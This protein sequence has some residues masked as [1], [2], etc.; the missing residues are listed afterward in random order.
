MIRDW[1]LR[2]YSYCSLKAE[3][4]WP[5]YIELLLSM[6][7]SKTE[8]Y[9]KADYLQTF[10]A[11]IPWPLGLAVFDCIVS[12]EARVASKVLQRACLCGIVDGV[13]GPRTIQQV[14]NYLQTMGQVALLDNFSEERRAFYRRRA[15]L[16]P[17]SAVHLRARLSRVDR[18]R[19]W[20]IGWLTKYDK[21]KD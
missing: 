4:I 3:E 12:D 9:H 20:A 19:D 13:V 7:D 18:V 21:R 6:D 15:K 1:D 14:F 17:Q 11:D 16:D 10:A 8:K 2:T 5:D